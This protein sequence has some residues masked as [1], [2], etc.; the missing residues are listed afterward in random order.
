MLKN[1]SNYLSGKYNQKLVD[2]AKQSA[3][4]AFKTVSKRAMQNIAD[5]ITKVSKNSPKTVESETENMEVDKE[6]PEK[7]YKTPNKGKLINEL[8][9][10]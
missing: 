4:D 3:T 9:L 8:R 5:K 7:R 1:R 10:I 2:H 6:I